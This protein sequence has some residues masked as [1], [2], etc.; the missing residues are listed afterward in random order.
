[1]SGAR[2]PTRASRTRRAYSASYKR[3]SVAYGRG[4]IWIDNRDPASS[5][6]TTIGWARRY[7]AADG[8]LYA[9][10]LAAYFFLTAL[11]LLLVE[12]SYVYND[13]S[14]LATRVEHRLRLGAETSTLFN[15]V[16]L[17]AS[18]HKLS[19]ALIAIVNV[20]FFGLGFGRV[21]QL[22]HARVWGI[23]LRKSVLVDQ[24]RYLQIVGALFLLTFLYVGQTKAFHGQ[25]S[26]LGWVVDVAWVALLVGY[27]VWAPHRL[28]HG[29]IAARDILPGA[30]FAVLGLILMRVISG[31]LLKRWLE[32]YSTTYGALGIVMALFFWIVIFTTILVLAAALSPSLAA[33]RELRRERGALNAGTEPG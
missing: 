25:P 3:G 11:P 29:R 30:V 17:G 7:Q 12:S 22:V 26:W 4:L 21:L 1:M 2:E 8:Q 14:A 13:P 23:D 15:A 32:W 16:M 5:V 28:L 18:G 31:F 24:V 27:F 19:A 6:G 10:L 9:V 20:F 33:R